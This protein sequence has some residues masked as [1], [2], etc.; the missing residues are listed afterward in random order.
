MKDKIKQIVA[1]ILYINSSEEI[2]DQASLFADL[3]V[4]SIDYIDLCFELKRC[5]DKQVDQD[6][7]WPINKMLINNKYYDNDQWTDVGWS[8]VCSL[9]DLSSSVEKMSVQKLY[10]FFTVN[11]IEKRLRDIL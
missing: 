4:S 6:N 7:L 10:D 2:S 9:L 8:E 3:G 11:Y 1:D 5:F